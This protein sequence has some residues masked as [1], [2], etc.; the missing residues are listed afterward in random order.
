MPLRISFFCRNTVLRWGTLSPRSIYAAFFVASALAIVAC[1]SK[2][3][4]VHE[5]PHEEVN[6]G[7]AEVDAGPPPP[8]QSLYDRLGK[9]EGLTKIVDTFSKNLATDN[10]FNK[11]LAAVKG[12]KLEKLKKDLVDQMCVESGGPENGA[13]CKYEGRFMKEA[14]GTKT[15]M[16]E[17]EWQAML[18]DL[19]AALE[20]QGVK[21]TEQQDLAAALGKF[22]DDVV[23]A[24]K[25]APGGK[26]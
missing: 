5:P 22:R 12:P 2:K 16:K 8:P 23:V 19:R 4:V 3:P 18:V 11:R 10:K 24:P 26:H 1:G 14:L 15:K 25:G 7:P 6:A 20:E 9:T 17:D 13:D 21:D